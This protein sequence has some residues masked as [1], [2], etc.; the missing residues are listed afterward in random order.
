M[1]R[2]TCAGYRK[3]RGAAALECAIVFPITFF[4]TFGII[5]GS[6]GVFRYQE[7]ASLAREGAR[8]ACVHG[9]DYATD[10]GKPAAT[11]DDVYSNAIQ[12]RMI[13]L[14]PQK[15]N[16][17]V[18]WAGNSKAPGST[19]TVTV[20]YTWVPELYLVGPYTLRSTENMTVA[21]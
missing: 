14:D 13:S 8:Y 1:F 21:Y 17:T 5:I 11:A 16:Y 12:P 15:V 4:L 10:S 18:T 2:R 9:T 6:L 20:S 7:V 3:R 19:V